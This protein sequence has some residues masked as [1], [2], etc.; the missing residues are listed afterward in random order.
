MY[1]KNESGELRSWSE[2]VDP[3]KARLLRKNLPPGFVSP[4]WGSFAGTIQFLAPTAE[5][6]HGEARARARHTAKRE[7]EKAAGPFPDHPRGRSRL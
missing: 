6:R 2:V 1:G 7:A 4:F 5:R 3:V